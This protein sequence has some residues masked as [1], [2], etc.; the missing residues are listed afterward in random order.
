M[1]FSVGS[2]LTLLLFSRPFMYQQRWS[3]FLPLLIFIHEEYPQNHPFSEPHKQA[4]FA[5]IQSKLESEISRIKFESTHVTSK[6]FIL[7][8]GL[9]TIKRSLLKNKYVSKM[10]VYSFFCSVNCSKTW[11]KCGL[12]N[13]I[14]LMY[15]NKIN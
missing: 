2:F 8:V 12:H 13:I 5:Q 6:I 1:V 15:S 3:Y 10:H 4:F 14:Y 9:E 11:L 7:L